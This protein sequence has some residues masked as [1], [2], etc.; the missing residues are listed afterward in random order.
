M[1]SQYLCRERQKLKLGLSH[2][3]QGV[4]DPRLETINLQYE[5][6][7]VISKNNP[8]IEDNPAYCTSG[9]PPLSDN[10]A[11][12]AIKNNPVIED[13]PAY[14]TSSGPPLSDNPAYRTIKNNPV[15]TT[16]HSNN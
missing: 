14:C 7:N 16:H 10:P 6:V 8:V 13:N 15:T 5:S 11:Y 3:K 9:G 2:S 1:N 12:S 4:P